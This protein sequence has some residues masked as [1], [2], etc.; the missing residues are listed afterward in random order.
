MLRVP[1]C[2]YPLDVICF[3]IFVKDDL[4]FASAIVGLHLY[5]LSVVVRLVFIF[6]D[7]EV[8]KL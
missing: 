1:L 8:Q 4:T 6:I 2:L 7:S 3:V 5:L